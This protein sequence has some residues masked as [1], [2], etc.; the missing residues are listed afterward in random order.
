MRAKRTIFFSNPK[1]SSKALMQPH[2]QRTV[3]RIQSAKTDYILSIQD[4]V[5]LN[6]TSHKAKTEMGLISRTEHRD[7]YGLIQH[8]TL[9]VTDQNESLGLLDLQHFHH[10]D[11]DTDI[12][13]DKRMIEEKKD[14]CWINASRAR[15]ALLG[16]TNKK[17]ITVADREGDFFEF[18]HDLWIHKESFVIRAQHNRSIGEKNLKNNN[19]K[20]FELLHSQTI[21]GTIQ[22]CINDVDTHEIKH[23]ELKIKKLGDIQLPPAFKL[24]RQMPQYKPITANAV[25]AY[26]ETYC[27]ILLTD[28]PVETLANCERVISIYKSRWHIEDYHKILKTG[29]QV[30]EIYL[31]ASRQAVENAL[32]MAS[33]SACRLYWLIYTGRVAESIKADRLFAAYEWKSLYVYFKE[34]VPLE[35]PSLS[36]II[37]KIARLGGYKQK[38][39]DRPPGIKTMWLGFQSFTVIAQMYYNMST[40]T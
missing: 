22:A 6:Y 36:T 30:D 35:T 14:I 33:L 28:L 4:S 7:Q 25:L 9:C 34:K 2:L 39:N 15:R 29:Y 32:T 16:H 27:W 40:K 3:A 26:N 5:V 23:I 21:F 31:H 24:L 17:I 11:F 12:P 19:T 8:N 37:L 18:L 13:R 1:V 38:K 20:L 10:D